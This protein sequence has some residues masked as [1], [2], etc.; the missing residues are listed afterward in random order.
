M[1][2]RLDAGNTP[3]DPSESEGLIPK[4]STQAEL[5]EFEARN[6]LEAVL[7]AKTNPK[8][9]KDLLDIDALCLLH[10]KMFDRTW[11]WAGRFRK[12]Q[13]SIGVE[14]FRISSE[15]KN[16]VED[17]KAW[18]EFESYPA[19]EIVARFHH[20]L[21]F[22]HPFPNGNGRHARLAADLLARQL[23]ITPFS[24]GAHSRLSLEEVRRNYIEALQE[25]DRHDFAKLL[26]FVRS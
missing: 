6:I 15:L 1:D 2:F 9:L 21:V 7:W 16:L 19:D 8:A 24:W 3:L 20:R 17:V 10:R 4:L 13:K 14:A 12:T 18:I 26:K 23:G 22:I 11:R 25:A 5:N